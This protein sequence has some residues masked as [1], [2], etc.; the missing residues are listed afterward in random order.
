M[1]NYYL[2]RGLIN[3]FAV[4]GHNVSTRNLRKPKAQK[5][6]ILA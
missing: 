5:T 3:C 4:L 1:T 6:Q 2:I